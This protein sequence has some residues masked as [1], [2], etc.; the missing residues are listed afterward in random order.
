MSEAVHP[1]VP[2]PEALAARLRAK[3]EGALAQAYRICF[4]GE[5]GRYVLAH[6]LAEA[7]IGQVRG[8]DMGG[9][10][11]AFWDG[12]MATAITIMNRAGADEASAAVTVLSES[13]KLEGRNDERSADGFGGADRNPGDWIGD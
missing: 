1:S 5:V 11:R 3:D 4:G 6:I 2:D 9:E 12:R 10:A 13:D 8:P 7:G